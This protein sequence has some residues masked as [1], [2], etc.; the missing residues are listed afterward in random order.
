VCHGIDLIEEDLEADRLP[1]I[2]VASSQ[3]HAFP[4]AAHGGCRQCEQRDAL[5][6][7]DRLQ[8]A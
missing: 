8:G 6:G 7:I 3:Q 5:G 1:D 4:I 2:A